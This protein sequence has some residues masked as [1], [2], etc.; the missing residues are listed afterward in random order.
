MTHRL[1]ADTQSKGGV[2]HGHNDYVTGTLQALTA[3]Q[4]I[5]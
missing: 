5:F 2:P 1:M 4:P 3:R